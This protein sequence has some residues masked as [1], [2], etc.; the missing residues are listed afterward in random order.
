MVICVLDVEDAA[1]DLTNQKLE[2]SDLD[3]QCCVK[4]II[5]L[6]KITSELK[7]AMKI[8]EILKEVLGV[9]YKMVSNDK[10]NFV[11]HKRRLLLT[12]NNE[13][14]SRVNANQKKKKADR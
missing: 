13:N 11:D 4:Q 7:S 2:N 5:E 14:W 1:T 3:S 9:T 12:P 10:S 8:I 6:N